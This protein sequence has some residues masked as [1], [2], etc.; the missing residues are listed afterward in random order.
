MNNHKVLNIASLAT[1]NV[2]RQRLCYGVLAVVT[3]LISISVFVGNIICK[4]IENGISVTKLRIGADIIVVPDSYAE[5]LKESL[6]QGKPCTIAFDAS[7]KDKLEKVDGVEE[8]SG[9]LYIAT[10]TDSPCCD[11]AIQLVAIQPKSDFAV[12]A[13]LYDMNID[14]VGDDEVIIGSSVGVSKGDTVKYYGKKFKVAG[15]LEESGMG[16]DYSAFISIVAA[17]EIAANPIY[18]NYLSFS[19][20]DDVMSAIMIKVSDEKDPSDVIKSINK[21]YPGA[22]LTAYTTDSLMKNMVN[23]LSA[24]RLFSVILDII[25]FLIAGV[26]LFAI[27]TNTFY[28]RKIEFGSMLSIGI[29]K[30]KIIQIL[31]I[32]SSVTVLISSAVGIFLA[33]LIVFPFKY[34]IRTFLQLSYQSLK[35]TDV[36]VF[37]L[38]TIL[39]NFAIVLIS[40][41]FII[42][43]IK[44]IQPAHLVNGGDV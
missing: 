28:M 17:K 40:S 18:K 31:I 39:L 13:W 6:F 24:F 3:I 34:Q 41:A 8:I 2:F 9:Q 32:E 38:I 44:K 33:G 21:E 7:W 12:K 11:N 25:L 10:M 36:L 30:V 1:N 19:D 14:D 4:S 20:K 42:T 22:P 37:A 5:V 16:Y 23:S 27:L 15:V 26:S 29:S 35:V 43:K